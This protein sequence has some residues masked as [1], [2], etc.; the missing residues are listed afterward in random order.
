MDLAVAVASEIVMIEEEHAQ[1]YAQALKIALD[2]PDWVAKT[3]AHGPI[4]QDIGTTVAELE[5]SEEARTLEAGLWSF[6]FHDTK[7]AWA[8][9][10]LPPPG[11]QTR[12]TLVAPIVPT[13]DDGW[14]IEDIFVQRAR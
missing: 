11:S 2:N 14:V 3:K 5:Y 7:P 1:A 9:Y 8:M 12:I 10:M 13:D 6:T 4:T